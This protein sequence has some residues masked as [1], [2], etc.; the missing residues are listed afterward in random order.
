[1]WQN[2]EISIAS[3]RIISE[4]MKVLHRT[5]NSIRIEFYVGFEVVFKTFFLNEGVWQINGRFFLKFIDQ[6][7][8]EIEI[9]H[10][11]STD[12]SE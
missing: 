3:G 9:V 8:V 2:C 10:Q 12:Q 11:K 7:T 5:T 4:K 6:A 1:M